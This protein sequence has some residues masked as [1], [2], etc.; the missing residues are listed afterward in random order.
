MRLAS[1]LC[2]LGIQGHCYRSRTGKLER[3]FKPS[4]IDETVIPRQPLDLTVVRVRTA[5]GVSDV[6]CRVMP[7]GLIGWDLLT[8]WAGVIIIVD[9]EIIRCS[10]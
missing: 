9:V 6:V 10:G 8:P 1:N 7:E 3:W 4:W 2:P 5:A